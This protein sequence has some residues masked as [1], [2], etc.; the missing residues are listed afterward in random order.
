MFRLNTWTNKRV[1]HSRAHARKMHAHI[2]MTVGTEYTSCSAAD[3]RAEQSVASTPF[4]NRIPC[5]FSHICNTREEQVSAI[6]TWAACCVTATQSCLV[7][8]GVC[9]AASADLLP[10]QYSTQDPDLY[11]HRM[12]SILRVFLHRYIS[13]ICK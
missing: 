8:R 10:S 1:C 6:R 3:Y 12:P 2:S 11:H 4:K 5:M 9:G 7:Q 13:P